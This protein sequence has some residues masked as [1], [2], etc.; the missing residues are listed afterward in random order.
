M[1]FLKKKKEPKDKSY[2]INAF[3]TVSVVILAFVSALLFR[4]SAGVIATLPLA[5]IIFAASAFIKINS[6]IKLT[7]FGVTV[8]ALNTVETDD[9]TATLIFVALC[10]LACLLFEV[11]VKLMKQYKKSGMCMYAVSFVL[12]VALSFVFLGNPI[13]AVKANGILKDYT[14][15]KY[16]TE[17]TE[18]S[19]DYIFSKIYYN[20]KTKAFEIQGYGTNSPTEIG[21]IS[22]NGETV[23]D[24]LK[25]IV[26]KNL[27]QPYVLEITEVLRNRFPDDTFTVRADEI[28]KINGK[29]VIVAEKNELYGRIV[30][31][32]N[33]GGVQT[34]D[35]MAEKVAQYTEVL[36][37]ANV[38]YGKIVY[39]SGISPWMKR[40]A[41]VDK[42]RPMGKCVF[43]VSHVPV[44]TSNRF[45][46]FT[47]S[48]F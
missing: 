4:R 25:P 9:V 17:E 8:F 35:K 21:T 40:S 24:G 34:A 6:K 23:Y 20:Y 46:R 5:F 13:S 32:I 37:N 43:N 36:D 41:T 22:V 39:K 7:V 42:N 2:Y 44:S 12:C 19:A 10:L 27:T 3:K 38:N 47:E 15:S 29:Q 26:Q 18:N 16:K 1:T 14:Q 31:E 33:L 28:Y 48:L 11:A 45:N 30:F